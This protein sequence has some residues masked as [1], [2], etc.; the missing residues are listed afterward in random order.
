MSIPTAEQILYV[1]NDCEP[2]DLEALEFCV[3]TAGSRYDI[4]GNKLAAGEPAN[5]WPFLCGELLVLGE[6][7]REPFNEGR[8]PSKWSVEVFE[9]RNYAA[10]LALS[11]LIKSGLA[12]ANGLY[13]WLDGL[14]VQP[15]DQDAVKERRRADRSALIAQI[16]DQD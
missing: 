14:W 15:D 4:R 16:G 6:S 9:T 12:T 1:L 2:V 13:E 8:K 5:Y 3:I 11:E 7:G 10:A